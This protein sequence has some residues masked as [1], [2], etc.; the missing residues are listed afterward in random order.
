MLF[1]RNTLCL[2]LL[3]GLCTISVAGYSQAAQDSLPSVL[4]PEKK[5]EFKGGVGGWIKFLESNL[6]RDLL[7]RQSAPTGSYRVTGNFLVDA[8]GNVS[9]IR[10]QA[11][12]GYGTAA[13]YIRVLKL[14]SGKWIP[15]TDKGITVPFRHV[16]S[17]TLQK[18]Y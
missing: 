6:N 15:A 3:I 8:A 4:N 13:E 5:A 10:I 12:P 18:G 2:F 17:L 11:D 9:D 16:Q 1:M 7:E 14:S